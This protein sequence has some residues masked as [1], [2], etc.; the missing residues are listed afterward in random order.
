VIVEGEP[1]ETLVATALAREA[2]LLVIGTH[3]RRGLKRLIM[4]GVAER[5]VATAPLPVLVVRR[6]C[7]PCRG[8][9]R[10]ILAPFDGSAF[11]RAALRQACR[12]AK[13]DGGTVSAFYAIPR[14]EE[15]V[16]FVRSEGIRER[17]EREARKILEEASVL[18][19]GQGVTAGGEIADGPASDRIV[20]AA[21]RLGSDLIAIGSHGHRGM[22]KI[23]LGSTAERV[24]VNAPCPV[25]VVKER[26]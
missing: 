23:L 14:Y 4:G 8:E 12:L 16:G 18:A 6:T 5:V 9:Y 10:K 2:D 19:A 15:M 7:E 20:E 13:A 22:D 11:S 1:P 17:L 26:P 24:I 3:G 25:L 21:K